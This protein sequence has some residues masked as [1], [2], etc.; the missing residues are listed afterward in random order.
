MSDMFAELRDLYS[1]E[2]IDRGRRPRNMR[3]LAAFD[4]TAKGDNPMCGD[5]VQVW[6]RHGAD[7]TLAEVGFK[8]Q[9][10]ELTKAA[11]DLMVEAVQGRSPADVRTLF[12]QYRGMVQTGRC[13]DCDDALTA[14]KPLAHVHEYSSR[15][16]CATLPWTALVAALDGRKESSSE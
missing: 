1:A 9:G 5:R 8:A 11:A 3:P 16:K 14:L 6:I 10:C 15:I 2:I 7:D 4:A 13:P 12:G